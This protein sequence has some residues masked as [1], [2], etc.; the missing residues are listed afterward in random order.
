M[1][2]ERTDTFERYIECLH[3]VAQSAPLDSGERWRVSSL[4]RHF[5]ALSISSSLADSGAL[6]REILRLQ[7]WVC[8]IPACGFPICES[9]WR[10]LDRFGISIQQ[11]GQM[12]RLFAA[13]RPAHSDLPEEVWKSMVIDDRNRRIRETAVPDA[14]LT[15]FFPSYVSYQN[16]TQK[17]A[18]RALLTMPPGA[19]MLVTI[20]TGGGK[21]LLFELP[22]LWWR[23]R[24][25]AERPCVL[26]VVP[27]VAL[28]I[29]HEN[30]LRAI[31]GLEGARAL[32][33][34]LGFDA[35]Q[36]IRQQFLRGEIPVLIASP[37]MLMG[38]AHSWILKAALPRD[39]RVLAAEGHLSAIFVDEAHIIESWGRS[40]RPDFQRLPGLVQELRNVNR[41]LRVVLLSATISNRARRELR[42]GYKPAASEW[43]EIDAEVPR[44]EFDLV[45]VKFDTHKTR[46]EALLETIDYAP[47]PAIVYTTLV[48]DAESLYRTL[49]ENRKY[50]RVALVTGESSEPFSRQEVVEEWVKDGFDLVIATS[51]FGMGIDKADVRAVIH[52]CVPESAARY[53]QEIGRA[54]RD[55]RQALALCLWWKSDGKD[56]EKR[57]DDLGFA[58]R[59]GVNQFLTVERGADRWRALL[60]DNADRQALPQF[61]AGHRV[62]DLSLDAH[63]SDILGM[64]GRRNRGWN[65]ILLNQLQRTGALEILEADPDLEAN[66]WKVSLHDPELLDTAPK[67]DAHL[68]EVLE[69]R[70]SERKEILEDIGILE[71]ILRD[72]SRDAG[73]VLV[74]LF[75]AV[76]SGT[77]D[78]DFCG[79]CWWCRQNRIP[80][81]STTH[82]H[83]GDF[84][85]S[86]DFS[87]TTQ[88]RREISIL[89]KDDHYSA[90]RELLIQR[91]ANVGVEQFIV[92]DDFGPTVAQV[93]A[94][95]SRRIGFCLTHSDLLQNGWK[96]IGVPTA[97]VFPNNGVDQSNKDRIWSVIRKQRSVLKHKPTLM[98]YVTPRALNLDGRPAVQVLCAGGF[99]EEQELDRW[100]IDA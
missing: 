19:A 58:Y 34:D 52:A 25:K 45:S 57:D 99:C 71:D 62:L 7:G 16:P 59:M 89:P 11:Q 73:C 43:I 68:V 63:P 51:A 97:I 5:K 85:K 17:S 54:G 76:E 27:T 13:D 72:H 12:L 56:L 14:I 83:L 31:P 81:P 65:M 94:G 64:T 24:D 15:R 42:R 6:L 93:L 18:V 66:R 38:N 3:K 26:L 61:E 84:W 87:F 55:G 4:S 92:P 28:A 22:T 33:S 80:P 41:D 2:S 37:E 70:T 74:R 75:S 32:K 20:P 29:A 69:S 47:R 98:L 8:Q 91:L 21:S 79:R 95:A 50:K 23:A 67:G 40:F 10:H 30:T 35:R 60:R 90:G 49:T 44:Y 100:R 82:Y 46:L 48:E 77:T 53:Y 1:N 78:A 9:N 39:K 36:Q 88:A 86:P 96:M